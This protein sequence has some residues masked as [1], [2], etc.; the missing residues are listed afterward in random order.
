MFENEPNKINN[1]SEAGK[2][3]NQDKLSKQESIPEWEQWKETMEEGADGD[4]KPVVISPDG[5]YYFLQKGE[6]FVIKRGK[7]ED[8]EA[9]I[10]SEDGKKEILRKSLA[11]EIIEQ[12]QEKEGKLSEARQ[13][14]R[15]EEEKKPEQKI[16]ERKE[17]KGEKEPANQEKLSEAELKKIKDK[18]SDLA[19]DVRRLSSILDWREDQRFNSLIDPEKI[20]RMRGAALRL[21]EIISNKETDIDDI[22]HSLN[23]IVNGFDAIGNIRRGYEIKDEVES[24]SQ[25]IFHLKQIQET[26]S[27]IKSMLSGFEKNE[28]KGLINLMRQTNEILEQK[29]LWIAKQRDALANYLR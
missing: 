10:V 6:R 4:F 3:E 18:L 17:G 5:A 24:L 15:S 16:D 21:E 29:W 28:T 13:K 11:E 12:E 20:S 22:G 27:R 1:K 9:A 23:G 25:V 26:V 14:L 8:Y 2:G 7:D 19:S